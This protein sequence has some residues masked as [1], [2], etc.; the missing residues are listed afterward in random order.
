MKFRIDLHVHSK[1]SGDSNAEPED[2]IIHAIESGLQGICFTE[3]YSYE[4][5][6]PVE[7]LREKYAD[8]IRIFRGVEFSAG[9]GH[10]LVFGVNTDRLVGKYMPMQ[11]LIRVVNGSGGVVIP[12]HPYRRGQGMGDLV[13]RLEGLCA[14]EGYNGF[15]MPAYNATAVDMAKAM[16]LPYTG[17]SDAHEPKEA[18][19]CY[20]EFDDEVT[21]DN[22]IELLKK[23]NYRGI[24]NRK[25]SF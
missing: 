12:S 18:G 9:E 15:N 8:S 19:L 16:R 10:C 5:S 14:I 21:Y 25:R 17:G 7:R 4:A 20:T 23:G 1:Y 3:H 22:F 24:D 6:G 11:D 2:L 13:L